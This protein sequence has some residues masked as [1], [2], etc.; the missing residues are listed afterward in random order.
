MSYLKDLWTYDRFIMTCQLFDPLL[1]AMG[2]VLDVMGEV[3]SF[4]SIHE[5]A[6]QLYY[7]HVPSSNM[8]IVE[9]SC[10]LLRIIPNIFRLNDICSM[11]RREFDDIPLHIVS[12]TELMYNVHTPGHPYYQTM[13][14]YER[15]LYFKVYTSQVELCTAIS[16]QTYD[17][18]TQKIIPVRHTW[19][20]KDE[21][22]MMVIELKCYQCL[23]RSTTKKCSPVVW[24]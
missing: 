20:V 17:Y 11:T 7:H 21:C 19:S 2:F 23:D 10:E 3:L 5:L 22:R 24:V 15:S 4:L 1:A 8:M 18:G 6:T 12:A 9:V 16:S 14:T 13:Y